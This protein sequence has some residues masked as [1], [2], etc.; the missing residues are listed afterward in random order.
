VRQPPDSNV[1]PLSDLET[2][3]HH[4]LPQAL[5][6]RV[7]PVDMARRLAQEMEERS[8]ETPTGPYAHNEFAVALSPGDLEQLQPFQASL[9]SQLA[10]YLASLAESRGFRLLGPTC[11]GFEADESLQ[12][13]QF[14]V[15]SRAAGADLEQPTLEALAGEETGPRASIHVLSG[16]EESASLVVAGPS[17]T[18]GR[19]LLCNL[20]LSDPS[21][22]RK[23]A[24]ITVEAGSYVAHDLGSASGT[25]VGSERIQS[26]PLSDGDLLRLGGTTIEFRL[27]R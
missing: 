6:G 19:G 15:E 17:V 13:G 4:T 20:R 27:Q 22:A 12:P 7:K 9:A 24:R 11:V 18:I 8:A 25:F 16:P 21:V 23:H 3:L 2:A 1:H 5:R 10:E 26:H 14:E